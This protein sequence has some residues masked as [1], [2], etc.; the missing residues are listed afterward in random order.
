MAAITKIG[1]RFF[2]VHGTS[3]RKLKGQPQTGFASAAGARSFAH[4]VCKDIMGGRACRH[5][6]LKEFGGS[7]VNNRRLKPRRM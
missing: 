2:G 4:P 5:I 7:R 3:G 1:S 6:P